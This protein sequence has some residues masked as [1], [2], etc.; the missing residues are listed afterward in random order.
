MK[1]YESEEEGSSMNNERK[2]NMWNKVTTKTGHD[3]LNIKEEE[4]ER[5]GIQPYL[6]MI[7]NTEFKLVLWTHLDFIA[8]HRSGVYNII[9]Y[10]VLM[11]PSDL[12]KNI[13]CEERPLNIFIGKYNNAF[14]MTTFDSKIFPNKQFTPTYEL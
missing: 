10:V 6:I 2:M 12:V 3:I 13:S 1:Q 9:D 7:L 8:V 11:D 14:R 5:R 4:E